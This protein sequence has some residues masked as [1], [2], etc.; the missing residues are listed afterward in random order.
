MLALYSVGFLLYYSVGL[1]QTPLSGN[2]TNCPA[3]FFVR[4][5]QEIKM[6]GQ[7]RLLFN[8]R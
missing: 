7:Y 6:N 8:L 1:R 3:L 2:I 5:C 4:L